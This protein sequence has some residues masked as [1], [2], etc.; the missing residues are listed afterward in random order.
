[1]RKARRLEGFHQIGFIDAG[2]DK[3]KK[4]PNLGNAPTPKGIL[5]AKMGWKGNGGG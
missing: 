1:M 2:R 4:S 3:R 5:A